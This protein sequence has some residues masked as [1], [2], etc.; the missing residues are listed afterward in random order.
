MLRSHARIKIHNEAQKQLTD[1]QS[2]PQELD[3]WKDEAAVQIF[4]PLRPNPRIL[5]VDDVE[6]EE[7]S[8]VR[9]TEQEERQ[10]T[11]LQGRMQHF[12]ESVAS[13]AMDMEYFGKQLQYGAQRFCAKHGT[14]PRSH[15]CGVL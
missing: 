9:L 14:W 15:E 11:S 4:K 2:K 10:W 5:R 7:H 13:A 1:F 12:R 3:L 8:K 6:W